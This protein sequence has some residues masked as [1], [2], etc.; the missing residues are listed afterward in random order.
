VAATNIAR[1][2]GAKRL[3]LFHHDPGHD[4]AM[5]DRIER[6]ARSLFHACRA[7]RETTPITV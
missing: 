6:D 4:D 3:A 7:A 1:A 5:I 2:A